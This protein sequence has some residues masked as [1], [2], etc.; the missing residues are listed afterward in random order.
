[1]SMKEIDWIT[2]AVNETMK[3][4]QRIIAD[5][6]AERLSGLQDQHEDDGLCICGEKIN[7]CPDAYAH[8]SDGV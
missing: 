1:M 2:L 5:L 7:D 8:M 3:S 4:S 6:E